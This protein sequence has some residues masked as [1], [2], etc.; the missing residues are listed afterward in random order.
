MRRRIVLAMAFIAVVGVVVLGVPLAIVA[1]RIGHTEAQRRVDQEAVAVAFA[2]DDV[3]E[4]HHPVTSKK[5][6]ELA[7]DGYVVLTEADG[8]R[9]TGGDRVSGPSISASART[10]QGARIRLTVP[11]HDVNERALGSIL[12]VAGLGGL[13][14][15]S[16]V[17]VAI[18]LSGRLAAPLRNLAATSRRLGEG[19]FSAR[20]EHFGIAEPDA[21]ATALNESAARIESLVEAERE[22]SANASHQLRTPLT[23]LRMHLEEL[24]TA[25]DGDSAREEIDAALEQAD[26]LG[27][28][29]TDLLALARRGRAGPRVDADALELA[30]ARV[31]VWRTL[32][33]DAGREVALDAEPGCTARVSPGA[34]AQALDALLDNALHHGAGTATVSVHRGR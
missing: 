22:F 14:V 29:I 26:R 2:V 9:T 3:L 25:V 12:L 15:L 8:T 18:I 24:G 20:A 33:H 31:A 27:A 30:Q 13:G 32:F 6:D 1:S 10:G 17:V 23:A 34:L 11:S 7:K 19:D 21:V 16:A 28:T 4:A 5:L